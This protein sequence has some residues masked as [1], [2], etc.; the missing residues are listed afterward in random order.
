M[1]LPSAASRSVRVASRDDRTRSGFPAARQA[2]ESRYRLAGIPGSGHPYP[3]AGRWRPTVGRPRSTTGCGRAR[4]A[5]ARGPG[6]PGPGG[7]APGFRLTLPND[8]RILL[9]VTFKKM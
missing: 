7:A 3:P 5:G 2:P 9:T 8:G 4:G 6:A 1:T